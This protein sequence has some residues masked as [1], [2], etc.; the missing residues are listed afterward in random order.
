METPVRGTLTEGAAEASVLRAATAANELRRRTRCM[1]ELQ[2][3][4]RSG[5][6]V[7][8]ASSP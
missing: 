1:A 6:T 7:S 3:D 8:N 2:S 5:F 4:Q